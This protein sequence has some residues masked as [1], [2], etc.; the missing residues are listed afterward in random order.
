MGGRHEG[1]VGGLGGFLLSAVNSGGYLT[2][3]E[4]GFFFL[5]LQNVVWGGE[6]PFQQLEIQIYASQGH[7][8]STYGFLPDSF[9]SPQKHCLL[10]NIY[11]F[12]VNGHCAYCTGAGMDVVSVLLWRWV[13]TKDA[14]KWIIFV[15]KW[16]RR[17]WKLLLTSASN[18]CNSNEIEVWHSKTIKK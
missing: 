17:N 11:L 14:K 6:T 1:S 5:L 3:V 8:C 18:I 9:F 12:A 2:V 16:K 10:W 15:E 13:E 4:E 7:I